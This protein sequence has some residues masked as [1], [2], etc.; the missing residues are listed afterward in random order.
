M[1]MHDAPAQVEDMQQKMFAPPRVKL[2]TIRD[3]R[4]QLAK[5]YQDFVD[6]RIDA[7]AAN[8]RTFMLMTMT[9]VI[10]DIEIEAR[11]RAIEASFEDYAS[12][13]SRSN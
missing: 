4:R 13:N 2:T 12:A 6:G 1:L 9:K 7:R 10:G 3:C 5:T 8:T 11:V